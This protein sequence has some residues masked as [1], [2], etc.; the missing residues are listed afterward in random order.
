VANS[1]TLDA[2]GKN[3]GATGGTVKVLGSQVA[4]TDTAKVDV[5]GTS[6]GGTALIGGN[7]QGKGRE[8]NAATTTVAKGA[9]INADATVAGNGGK[10]V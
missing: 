7:A 4:L 9:T 3:A 10:V 5:S 2:S 1:G 6:G 8:Q